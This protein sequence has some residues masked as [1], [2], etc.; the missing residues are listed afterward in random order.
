[1]MT[2]TNGDTHLDDKHQHDD[3]KARKKR[4]TKGKEGKR[5]KSKWTHNLTRIGIRVNISELNELQIKRM[6]NPD[7]SCVPPH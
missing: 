4:S 7:L 1:M 6:E 2:R 3:L 5:W